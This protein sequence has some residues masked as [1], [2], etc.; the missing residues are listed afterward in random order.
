MD[1]NTNKSNFD[2]SAIKDATILALYGVG[3]GAVLTHLYLLKSSTGRRYTRDIHTFFFLI[4]AGIGCLLFY[5]APIFK[6]NPITNYGL[7]TAG[8]WIVSAVLTA[9]FYKHIRLKSLTERITVDLLSNNKKLSFEKIAP[10]IS[11]PENIPI[12]ISIVTGNIKTIEK[13]RMG[14][15]SLCIGATGA[16]KTSLMRTRLV[17][18]IKNNEACIIIDPKGSYKDISELK[19]FMDVLGYDKNK[20]NIFSLVT[21]ETSQSFNPIKYGTPI[22]KK[23]CI[24]SGLN[25]S[26]EFYGSQASMYLSILIPAL[27]A[28]GFPVTIN[29]ICR[30]LC[31]PDF[32]DRIILE[33]TKILDEHL[34]ERLLRNLDYVR[35][36]KSTDL[37]GIRAQ[38][39]DLDNLEFGYLLSPTTCPNKRELDLYRV[40]KNKEIAYFQLSVNG[41]ENSVASIGK[42]I[43]QNLKSLSSQIQTGQLENIDTVSVHIDEFGAFAQDNFDKFLKICRDS[44]I[45]VHMYTQGLADLAKINEQFESQVFGNNMTTFIF[46]LNVS[47]EIEKLISSAGTVD[48][49]EQSYQV[50]KFGISYFKTGAGNM[51]N[52]KQMLIEHDVVK[53]LSVGQAIVIERGPLKSDLIQVWNPSPHDLK[54]ISPEVPPEVPP[55]Q[56]S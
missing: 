15:H 4:F 7:K 2:S 1:S 13:R 9:L 25:L 10:Y 55:P 19:N 53:N 35:A 8:F 17:H 40:L 42:L 26:H 6:L 39:V 22:Q 5:F 12:G 38:L 52:T 46:R 36:I 28:I 18:S 23:D 48:T 24:L 16:G 44:N 14:M 54:G 32:I 41:Y 47:E 51:R 49:I 56:P 34:A 21:P 31:E 11:D 43:I 20:L 45:G 33:V 30:A 37:A 29:T 3:L 50:E 27:T